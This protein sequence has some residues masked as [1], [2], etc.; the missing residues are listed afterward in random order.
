VILI[1]STFLI[2]VFLGLETLFY[3]LFWFIKTEKSNFS[4]YKMIYIY[5]YNQF[6]D[7]FR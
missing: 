4:D 5:L 6:L 3:S 2:S 1:A 7:I